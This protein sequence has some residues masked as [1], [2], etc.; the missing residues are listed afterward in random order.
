MCY[1]IDEH[2]IVRTLYVACPLDLPPLTAQAAFDA[3]RQDAWL[4]RTGKT[5]VLETPATELRLVGNG[6]EEQPGPAW[7]LRQAPG[8]LRRRGALVSVAVQVEV[9]PWSDRTC[10]IGIRPG[11]RA[12]P[13]T[14]GRRQRQYFALAVE[15]AEGLADALEGRVEDW[16]VTQLAEA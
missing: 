5:W 14:D 4:D 9:A 10:E 3:H 12:V 6:P 16:M 15:A 2:P 8:R 7:A 1:D 13:M 11:C